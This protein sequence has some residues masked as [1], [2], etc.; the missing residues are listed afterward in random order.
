MEAS[1]KMQLY[2][3]PTTSRFTIKLSEN[4]NGQVEISDNSGRIIESI[5]FNGNIFNYDAQLAKGLYFIRI[6]TDQ[7]ERIVKTLIVN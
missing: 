4:I 7:N 5:P 2:P 1:F 6:D 3:N